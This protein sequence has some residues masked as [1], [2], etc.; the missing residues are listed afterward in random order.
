MR[1]SQKTEWALI[2][3]LI[4]YIAFT[5][6]FQVVRDLLS[7]G[8][9]KAVALAAVVATWKYV[10]PLVAVLLTVSLVRCAAMREYMED[11]P[12]AV[13]SASPCPP[14]HDLVAGKCKHKTT[15]QEIPIPSS[16]T[17]PSPPPTVSAP[18]T[19]SSTMA[20][21]PVTSMTST[22]VP[23]GV[24]PNQSSPKENFSIF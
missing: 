3:A 21:Q 1:I 20:K 8:V 24:V 18:P 13:S 14:E 16:S 10:S 22:P 5:P 9:G 7:T 2:A 19:E 4:A 6:G 23:G 12:P 15:G 17:P 11:T